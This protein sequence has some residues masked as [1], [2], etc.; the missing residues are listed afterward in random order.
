MLHVTWPKP[1]ATSTTMPAPPLKTKRK[2]A[3]A[4]KAFEGL[5]QRPHCGWCDQE[6]RETTGFSPGVGHLSC[7]CTRD[8]HCT[9]GDQRH[10]HAGIVQC[11]LFNNFC[12]IIF[13]LASIVKSLRLA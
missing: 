11:F 7:P 10:A 1:G 12:S 13:G 4:P 6:S 9:A 3:T 2:H 8:Q 5:T